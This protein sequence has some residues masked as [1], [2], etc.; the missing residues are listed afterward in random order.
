MQIVYIDV[1]V[2][3]NM[4]ED[5]LLLYAVKYILR[6]KARSFRLIMGSL[7]G[8]FLSLISLL[9]TPFLLSILIKVLLA[10]LLIL[11]V[12]GYINRKMLIK[13]SATLIITSFLINGAMICFYLALKPNGMI[14]INDSVYFDISPLLLI[15][16]T[17]II[18]FILLL[19]KKL[20]KNSAKNRLIKTVKITYNNYTST[21]KCKI[22]S[23]MNVKEPFSG[24]SVIIAEKS[25]LGFDIAENVCRIIPYNSLGGNGIIFGFK[26]SGVS[27]DD[28]NVNEEIYIGMCDGILND[29]IKGLIPENIS[30]E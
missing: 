22:D 19:Y 18:Y 4:F 25:S 2:F 23:G 28:K 13:A 26:A 21:I 5:F 14:I 11:I 6:L 8:G 12:F 30:G 10:F 16:L 15:I 1:M 24:S 3:T 20:F 17:L 9:K 7:A 27:I 29:E